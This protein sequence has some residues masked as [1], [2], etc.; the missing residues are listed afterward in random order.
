MGIRG[1]PVTPALEAECRAPGGR[2]WNIRRAP[3]GARI[4]SRPTLA[5]ELKALSIALAPAKRP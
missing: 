2:A 5:T 1:G 4:T 3:S